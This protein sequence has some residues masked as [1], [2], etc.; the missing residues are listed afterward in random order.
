[1]SDLLT[2]GEVAE[3]AHVA[4][5]AVRYYERKGLLSPDARESGQRRYRSETLRRLVFIRMLQEAGLTLEEIH[6]I[7]NAATVKEWKAIARRRLQALDQQIAD[8]QYA[9]SVLDA[10]LLCRFDHPATDCHIMGAEIDRRLDP[11]DVP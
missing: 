8:L 3:R 9:R 1:V 10:A 2:I 4:T 7:L 5:S 11:Q 6:Q